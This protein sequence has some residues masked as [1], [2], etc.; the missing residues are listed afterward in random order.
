ML[1]SALESFA[2]NDVAPSPVAPR[3]ADLKPEQPAPA[4]PPAV[5][6]VWAIA[7]AKPTPTPSAPMP[8]WRGIAALDDDPN[9]SS[10]SPVAPRKHDK[11][12]K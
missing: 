7:K 6:P 8:K 4:P 2:L 11:R 1:A 3:R 5:L 12:D 9:V 10:S